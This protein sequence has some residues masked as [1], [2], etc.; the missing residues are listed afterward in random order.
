MMGGPAATVAP[1]PA[2]EI[3]DYDYEDI[4]ARLE[5]LMKQQ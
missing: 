3:E 5:N 1:A 2:S 4:D